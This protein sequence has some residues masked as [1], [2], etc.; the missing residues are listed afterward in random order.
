MPT[1]PHALPLD[2]VCLVEKVEPVKHGPTSFSQSNPSNHY[3]EFH[4]EVFFS[5]YISELI[6]VKVYFIIVEIFRHTGLIMK[7][8]KDNR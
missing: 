8:F 2:P 5:A 6:E 4:L 7:A 3:M 1:N